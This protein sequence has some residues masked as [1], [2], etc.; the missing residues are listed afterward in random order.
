MGQKQ[1]LAVAIV[2]LAAIVAVVLL[3]QGG[4]GAAPAAG[5]PEP[6]QALEGK[7]LRA[8]SI[9]R[10]RPD[11]PSRRQARA[12][13]AVVEGRGFGLMPAYAQAV[14]TRTGE[15]A[16]VVPGKGFVCVMGS[17]PL[18]AGCDTTARVAAR[19]MSVVA[20]TPAPLAQDRKA[21][22]L[23]GVAPDGVERATVRREGGRAVAVPVAHN[24]F[25]YRG[26]T[27]MRASL[28]G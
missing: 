16:W 14:K 1:A 8:F 2:A 7:Q 13:E 4:D 27:N 10:H 3:D 17:E 25:S 28:G 24:V 21:Y 11:P 6:A 9:L 18:V 5:V 15:T 26:E 23:F 12:M 20:I 19:G 22:T